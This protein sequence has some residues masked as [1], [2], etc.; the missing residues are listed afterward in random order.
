MLR[1]RRPDMEVA[2]VWVVKQR[3]ERLPPPYQFSYQ[4]EIEKSGLGDVVFH[5]DEQAAIEQYLAA[6]TV[7]LS[8][9]ERPL[10][11][12]VSQATT[13]GLPVICFENSMDGT[14]AIGNSSLVVPYLDVE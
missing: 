13:A 7:F 11:D 12:L 10:P 8:S 14:D 1:K 6:D 4:D 9:R 3:T 2:C 5:I